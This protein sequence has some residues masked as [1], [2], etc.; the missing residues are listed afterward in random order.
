MSNITTNH[1]MTYTMKLMRSLTF[2]V[3][4]LFIQLVIKHNTFIHTLLFNE[5][6]FHWL[7]KVPR[8]L[9]KIFP[10]IKILSESYFFLCSLL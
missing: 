2:I 7:F 5:H 4:V 1:A 3:V 10:G 9:L 6:F 8:S